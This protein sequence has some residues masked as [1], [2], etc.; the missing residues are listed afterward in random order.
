M[1]R[2]TKAQPMGGA[3]ALQLHQLGGIF[4]RQRIRDGGHELRHL[5]DRA[6][7]AAERRREV[8]GVLAAIERQAEQARAGKARRHSA[9]IGADARIARSAGGES[10]G[11]A[12]G[13]LSLSCP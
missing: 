10:I 13:L 9:H 8:G 5:H 3:F 2:L 1:R 6:L 12:V 11:F 7:E 4:R